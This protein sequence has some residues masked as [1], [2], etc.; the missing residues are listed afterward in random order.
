M[1]A[2]SDISIEVLYVLPVGSP[3]AEDAADPGCDL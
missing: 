2:I 1:R 3:F